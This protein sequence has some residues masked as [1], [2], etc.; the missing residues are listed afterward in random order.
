METLLVVGASPNQLP[1][2]YTASELG[3]EVVAVD[4]H[5]DAIG[6]QYATH[7]EVVN[8]DVTNATIDIA[9]EYDVSG[10]LTMGADIGVPT[11]AAVR[12]ELELPGVGPET[13]RK[14]THKGIMMNTCEAA[15]ISIPD[16]IV[17][18]DPATAGTFFAS[19]AGPIVVKP[20]DSGGQRGV[21]IVRQSG[22]VE[23]AFEAAMQY[24]SNEQVLLQE[25]VQGPEINVTAIVT[26]G[27]IHLLSL[28]NRLTA[29][30]ERF[31]IAI[32]HCA[33]PDISR[34]DRS[35]VREIAESAISAIGI[36]NGIAYPQIIVGADGPRLVEIAARI[37]GGQMHKVTMYR[38]GVDLIRAAINYALGADFTIDDVSVE[39]PHRAVSVRFFTELDVR[40]E[41]RVLRSI[42]N[43][44]EA[45]SLPG[46]E[47]IDI[48]L[49]EGDPVPPLSDATDRFG[50]VL[51]TA[52]NSTAAREYAERAASLVTFV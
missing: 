15:G 18:T 17:A 41:V 10:A 44:D 5:S 33:P 8:D 46:V 9:R 24:A 32:E 13:A 40:E 14:A 34:A 29:D 37:P 11:V 38:S 50:Y 22:N 51:A 48:W 7:I 26:D 12:S 28:S 4:T 30:A 19:Q 20:T 2:I 42:R 43:L 23:S 21:H 36:E 49:T 52:V 45:R 1:L 31:G 3:Y 47:A 39:I 27:E 6:F 35:A 25:Y 16:S